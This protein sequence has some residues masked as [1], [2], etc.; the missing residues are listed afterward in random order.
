MEG[1]IGLLATTC[2]RAWRFGNQLSGTAEMRQRIVALATAELVVG[3]A[4]H[5]ARHDPP[6]TALV[7]Q[8]VVRYGPAAGRVVGAFDHRVSAA[9]MRVCVVGLSAAAR[10]A[11][12]SRLLGVHHAGTA[13]GHAPVVCLDATAR[14]RASDFVHHFSCA[15]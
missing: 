7:R 11:D 8:P 14:G 4:R 5:G 10:P 13:Y 6:A 15:A 1:V 9:E 2:V 3:T 12:V